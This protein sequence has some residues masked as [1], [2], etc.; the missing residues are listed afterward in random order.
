MPPERLNGGKKNLFLKFTYRIFF[1]LKF[2]LR[3]CLV[4]KKMEE[5]NLCQ[6]H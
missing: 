4:A 5:N 1:Y 3:L 2:F 6:H